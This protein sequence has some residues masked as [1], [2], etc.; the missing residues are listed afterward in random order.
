MVLSELLLVV[1][2]HDALAARSSRHIITIS[3]FSKHEILKYYPF[4]DENRVSVIYGA[5]DDTLFQPHAN[6]GTIKRTLCIGCLIT[7]PS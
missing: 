2:G 3:E 4:L 6:E 5:A 7:R 1:S